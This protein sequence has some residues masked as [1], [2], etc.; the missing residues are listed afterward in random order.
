MANEDP[1]GKVVTI[2][3]GYGKHDFK[4]AGVV[5]ESLGKSHLVA[6]IFV[7]M[8]SGG[9]GDYTLHNTMWAGNNY[10][11]SY[12]KLR[13]GADAAS[14]EQKLPA[15]LNKYGAQQLKAL[16]MQKKLHL[17]PVTSIHTTTGL[18]SGGK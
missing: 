15:F 10:A 8:N 18:R 9:F 3:N 5:D 17:Q 14:L 16:G 13:P 11:A 6:N 4:V 12:V 7:T 2:D 1:V